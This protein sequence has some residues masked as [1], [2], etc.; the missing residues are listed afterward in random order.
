MNEDVP[1]LQRN[2]LT[3]LSP[4]SLG[5]TGVLATKQPLKQKPDFSI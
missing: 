2:V 3:S 1:T 5:I 4:I